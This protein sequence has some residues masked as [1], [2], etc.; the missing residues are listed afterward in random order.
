MSETCEYCNDTG[1][2]KTTSN[3]Y[4]FFYCTHCNYE[5]RQDRALILIQNKII[6]DLQAAPEH[7]EGE[8][9]VSEICTRLG[10]DSEKFDSETWC[11]NFV[12][13]IVERFSPTGSKGNE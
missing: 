5:E 8:Y 2:V 11:E 7:N 12:R 13:E 10:W 6:K 9:I 4:G 1:K 3:E